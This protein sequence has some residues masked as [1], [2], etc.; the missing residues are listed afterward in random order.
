MPVNL[1]C[2]I[3]LQVLHLNVSC[4]LLL[5]ICSVH[6]KHGSPHMIQ[7]PSLHISPLQGTCYIVHIV[8]ADRGGLGEWG[9]LLA[10]CVNAEILPHSL[11]KNSLHLNVL[12]LPPLF[13]IKILNFVNIY[14]TPYTNLSAF[15]DTYSWSYTWLPDHTNQLSL[16]E[17]F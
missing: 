10:W 6:Q 9:L 4:H 5:L 8:L 1:E 16:I 13:K 15:S 7:T 14:R 3:Y 12:W 11:P 17:I 2:K